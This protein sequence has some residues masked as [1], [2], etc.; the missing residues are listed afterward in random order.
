M[1][2]GA[3]CPGPPP[4]QG[5]PPAL[6]SLPASCSCPPACG[7]PLQNTFWFCFPTSSLRAKPPP[8]G[9]CRAREKCQDA[10]TGRGGSPSEGAGVGGK[11]GALRS[12][13]SSWRCST[14]PRAA[15]SPPFSTPQRQNPKSSAGTPPAGIAGAGCS[16][17]E[18]EPCVGNPNR[19]QVAAGP[20]C[21]CPAGGRGLRPH[22]P[23]NGGPK[24]G[25]S[26]RSQRGPPGGARG[27]LFGYLHSAPSSAHPQKPRGWRGG[28]TQQQGE[29]QSP[30]GDP[31]IPRRGG[32]T[33]PGAP[34]PPPRHRGA[35]S[36]SA[37]RR[38]QRLPRAVFWD[39][40]LIF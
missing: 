4:Q 2:P 35:T 16:E 13:P 26:A 21:P 12:P 14:T 20:G 15:Q 38:G 8:G 36:G 33:P 1:E 19:G 29:L 5:P 18:P 23:K 3:P 22:A 9:V 7:W 34:A 40:L 25:A 31:P 6:Q 30:P 11:A 28:K 32:S 39:F 24:P 27:F 10:A 37:S 17:G